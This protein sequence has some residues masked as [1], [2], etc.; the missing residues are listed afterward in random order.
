MKRDWSL[1][2]VIL[3]HFES[4]TIENFIDDMKEPRKW[5]EGQYFSD[6][7]KQLS[8]DEKAQ[9]IIFEHIKLLINAGYVDGIEINGGARGND[10]TYA[11]YNPQLTNEGHDLL[12]AMRSENLWEKVQETAKKTGIEIS[13]QTLQY[14]IPSV[15]KNVLGI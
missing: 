5:F 9:R 13:I 12:Q 2:H 11:F 14:L 4:E 3:A 1:L 15:L 10:Y 7:C 6:R 8:E